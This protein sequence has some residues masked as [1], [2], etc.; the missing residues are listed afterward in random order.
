MNIII[1]GGT[2]FIG[3]HI[4][5]HLAESGHTI[6][7][8]AR[9][10][11][12]KQLDFSFI[13]ADLSKEESW[14]KEIRKADVVINLVGKNIFTR[15]D[16]KIKK[17]IFDSRIQSTTNIV[18]A[19]KEGGNKKTVLINA[20]AV[21]YY[22]FNE[23]ETLDERG[24]AGTDFLATVCQAWEKVAMKL[25]KEGNRVVIT[26]FGIVLGP[27]G[28]ALHKME[29]VF[30][31]GLGSKI[32]SGEQWFSWIHIHDLARIVGYMIQHETI[33]GVFNCTAPEP[34][35]NKELTKLLAAQLH[36]PSVLPPV[37]G[38][39]VKAALGETA[40]II[41]KGQKVIPKRLLDQGFV[42]TYPTLS[43][44]LEDIFHP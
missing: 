4:A 40:D 19:I 26:R 39:V 44:A 43:A 34:V 13:A 25:S 37:P 14:M 16:K 42:F 8:V 28:G 21:G 6:T 38:F 22:G 7:L 29:P 5:A 36:S 31:R 35:K 10:K 24:S 17:S 33:E 1:C 30:K 3:Q 9:D 23:R 32:G 2:G 11:P 20:S 41:L 27:D 18:K 12:T 15:W